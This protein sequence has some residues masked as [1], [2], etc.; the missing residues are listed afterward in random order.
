[1]EALPCWRG[2]LEFLISVKLFDSCEIEHFGRLQCPLAGCQKLSFEKLQ[3]AR[4]HVAL[5]FYFALLTYFRQGVFS[6]PIIIIIWITC[7]NHG[8]RSD[9]FIQIASPASLGLNANCMKGPVKFNHKK[10]LLACSNS[11]IAICKRL[12]LTILFFSPPGPRPL[13]L[14][15]ETTQLG[16]R[17]TVIRPASHSNCQGNGAVLRAFLWD[18]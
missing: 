11:G 6:R 5:F 15:A 10:R 3:M 9:P 16:A 13:L 12:F 17:D 2:R 14:F 4:A 18:C 8:T 1:M 7:T